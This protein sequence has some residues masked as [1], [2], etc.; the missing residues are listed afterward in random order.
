MQRFSLKLYACC[1]SSS[2]FDFSGNR[3]SFW[4][5]ASYKMRVLVLQRRL[6]GY[7]ITCLA[8]LLESEITGKVVAW[9]NQPD[10]PFSED[11]L[12]ASGEVQDRNALSD[13]EL[14]AMALEFK[15]DAVLVSGWSDAG[16]VKVCKALKARGVLI[17]S[18]CD[19][20]W[21]G[22]FRQH[23]ASVIAPWHVQTFIDVFWV[24][25]ERQRQLAA[26]LGYAGDRCWDGY[27]SCDWNLFSEIE[28]RRLDVVDG[29]SNKGGGV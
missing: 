13:A 19:T 12:S 28:Y 29:R 1:E 7:F 20:Q 15:P 14:L 18:G 17:V 4:E 9:P 3:V 27:Y 22:S 8:R 26:K 2:S 25:G 24:S 16:Y 6:S 11:V 23:V 10:A 5:V 21:K